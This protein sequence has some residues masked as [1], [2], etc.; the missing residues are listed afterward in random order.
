[1]RSRAGIFLLSVVVLLAA[2]ASSTNAVQ[3]GDPGYD[4]KITT[5]RQLLKSRNL[6]G[7]IA[8]LEVMFESSPTDQLVINL[9]RNTYEDSKNYA[10]SELLARRLVEQDSTS[11]NWRIYLAESLA[12]QGQIGPA[13]MEYRAA[14]ALTLPADSGRL[15]GIFQSMMAFGAHNGALAIIDDIRARSGQDKAFGL[16]RGMMLQLDR[17]YAESAR[18]LFSVLSDDSAYAAGDAERQLL[19]LLEYADATADVEQ[20]LMSVTG[21]VNS[22]RALRLLTSYAIKVGEY[23]RALEFAVRQDTLQK[24]QG[25]PLADLVRQCFDRKAY[26][27]TVRAAE[28]TL[29]R[30]DNGPFLSQLRFQHAEALAKLGRHDASLAAYQKIAATIPTQADRGDAY[31]GIAELYLDQTNDPKQAI[32]YFDSVLA[33]PTRG[34]SYL[35][36]VRLTPVCYIRLGDYET[37]ALRL[38]KIVTMGFSDDI[39]EE[40]EYRLSLLELF[41]HKF[42]STK[43][44]LKKLMVDHPRGMYVNDAMQ[45]MIDL[46]QVLPDTTLLGLY[47]RAVEYDTRRIPDSARRALG[48]LADAPDQKLADVALY[49]LA[50]LEV[51]ENDTTAALGAL[52]HLTETFPESFY[53]PYGLKLKADLIVDRTN[54]RDKARQIYR[55]LLEKYPNSPFISDARKRLRAIEE[56]GRVG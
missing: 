37:A 16:Q 32:N 41:G 10:K 22:V 27:A 4:E 6:D 29:A 3:Q 28:Y 34:V 47:A 14:Y 54:E 49:R 25:A 52:D 33:L 1:M 18:E 2:L 20:V 31:C 53:R 42:D 39:L 17:R 23:D 8:M 35:K 11:Y 38:E 30:Y 50:K 48:Q 43:I 26:D 46:D 51:G 45:M 56:E 12:K 21:N 40:A 44:M 7:A 9:L 5:V 13:E 36:A 15:Y 24:G 19:S 55:E